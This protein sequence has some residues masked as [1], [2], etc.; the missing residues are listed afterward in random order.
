MDTQRLILLV[1]FSFS[2]LMLWEA[3]EKD[4]RPKPSAAPPVAQQAIPV[5]TK[6]A[7]PAAGQTP[8]AAPSGA[9]PAASAPA[10]GE[11]VRVSTDLM[12][13]EVDTVGATLKRV[14]LLRHKDSKELSK[15]LTLLG[16]VHHYEAQSGLAGEGGPNHRTLW[17]VQPG[18]RELAAGQ[19]SYELRFSA[20]GKDGVEVQ[21]I[22]TFHRGSYVVDVTLELRNPGSALLATYSY[23]QLTHD[24]KPDANPNTVAETFGAQSFIGFAVYTDEHKFEKVHPADLDKGKAGHVKQA[25][26]GWLAFVQHYFVSAWRPAQGIARDYV[27]EK[28]QDGIYAGR[29]MVPVNLAPGASSRLVVPLYAG[30]QEQRHL[31]AAAPGMD[32]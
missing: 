13:A 21:K 9:V 32:L 27:T 5:P 26:N 19:E 16:P 6:P 31:Q 22:Y 11:L 28:R 4:K 2:V 18:A 23:F 17:R 7:A 25:T 12:I 29:V 15:N 14:E 1:I 8:A 3:W 20:T 30:P 24:G 10:Q